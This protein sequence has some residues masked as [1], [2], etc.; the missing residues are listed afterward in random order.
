MRLKIKMLAISAV[1][2]AVTVSGCTTTTKVAAVQPGDAAMS[3]EQL[4]NEFGRLDTIV[5]E[6]ERNQGVNTANVAA[7][8]LFWPAAVGNWLNADEAK[9]LVNERRT[10]LMTI[11]NN[12]RCDG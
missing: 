7:V 2:L 10:H 4:T 5:R 1:G 12:K 6:A 11:Y 9:D 8:L 3:C